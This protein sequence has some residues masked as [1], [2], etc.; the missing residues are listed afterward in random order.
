MVLSFQFSEEI[1]FLWRL[2]RAYGD[3]YDLSTNTQ[4]K[5]HYANIGKSFVKTGCSQMALFSTINH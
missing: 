2:A 5:K 1:E 4:E 3:M